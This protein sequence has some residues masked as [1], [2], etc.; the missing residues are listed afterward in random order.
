MIVF[1]KFFCLINNWFRHLIINFVGFDWTFFVIL[2]ILNLI[3][4]DKVIICFIKVFFVDHVLVT[5]IFN[6]FFFNY[7]CCLLKLLRVFV[8]INF[9]FDLLQELKI[10]ILIILILLLDFLYIRFL[11]FRFRILFDGSGSLASSRSLATCFFFLGER[12]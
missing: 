7:F 2:L 9:W 1:I 5:S 4:L 12:L 3:L 6:N 8:F 10:F 11:S